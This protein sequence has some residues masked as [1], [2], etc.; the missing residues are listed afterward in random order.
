MKLKSNNQWQVRAEVA[1]SLG[2]VKSNRSLNQLRLMLE[3]H[4]DRVKA[5]VIEGLGNY[6][7][8]RNIDIIKAALN[9]SDDTAV[10]SIA[11]DILGSSESPRALEILIE[12]ARRNFETENV[13][14]ARSLISAI[15]NFTD[16]TETG[17]SASSTIEN[18]LGHRNRIVR[19]DAFAALKEKAPE[20]YSPGIFN[21]DIDEDDLKNYQALKKMGVVAIIETGR[22][23][24][25]IKLEP[26]LAPRTTANF[27][28]LAERGFYDNLTFHRVV[29]NFVVQGGCPRADGWGGPG[30]MIREEINPIRFKRGT[31][32]M[33][34]SGRDT[35]G[36]QFFICLSDQPHLD[37]RY[38]AFGNVI[39][40]RDIL[41]KIE[42]GDS[43]ISV[44]IE[45]GRF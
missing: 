27:V 19:Q 32:G 39:D 8:I 35:G 13:D 7:V 28:R 21:V 15:G 42:I 17:I 9:G 26:V 34:T 10:K 1:R 3:D 23:V 12:T 4:D 24:V 31:I 37:G 2:K 38:T 41:D 22:G 14:F 30:Y 43:I 45:K 25:K 36:S 18:F 5:A 40:G 33:A 20:N 11:A 16:T 29:Q 6:P 44:K